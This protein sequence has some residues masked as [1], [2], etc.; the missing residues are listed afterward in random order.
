MKKTVHGRKWLH[1][2]PYQLLRVDLRLNT[3]LLQGGMCGKGSLLVKPS[4]SLG[5]SVA[6]RTLFW[7]YRLLVM[8]PYVRSVAHV[9]GQAFGREQGV[10]QVS[11]VCPLSLQV[12]NPLYLTKLPGMVLPPNTPLCPMYTY[13]FPISHVLH[14]LASPCILPQLSSF[15]QSATVCRHPKK[16]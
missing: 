2:I 1:T 12:S 6:W 14:G 15:C 4:G 5:T 3:F 16:L 13:C 10:A 8:F 9:P 11:G 7:A